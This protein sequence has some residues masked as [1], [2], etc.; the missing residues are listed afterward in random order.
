M[1][2]TVII[3]VWLLTISVSL[4]NDTPRTKKEF[5]QKVRQQE[6][7]I[8]ELEAVVKSQQAEIMMLRTLCKEAGFDTIKIEEGISKLKKENIADKFEL[9][10]KVG[11]IAYLGA[12]QSIRAEQII[13]KKNMLVKLTIGYKP[14][15]AA[16]SG[17]SRYLTRGPAVIGYEAITKTV[18]IRG[19]DTSNQVDGSVIKM[20]VPL[21]V[22]RTKTYEIVSGGTRTVFVLEPYINL[23]IP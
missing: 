12:N 1:K 15:R 5:L 23:P 19:F 10:L 16:T 7:R 14:I 20:I 6:A 22:I 8:K 2:K 21:K 9:P 11:Q 13:D 18:W 3:L 4:A 17:H